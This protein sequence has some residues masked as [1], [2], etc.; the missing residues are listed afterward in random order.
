MNN[1]SAPAFQMH[2]CCFDYMKRHNKSLKIMLSCYAP[3]ILSLPNIILLHTPRFQN[4]PR[5][6]QILKTKPRK[7]KH[8]PLGPPFTILKYPALTQMA[9]PIPAPAAVDFVLVCSRVLSKKG[10]LVG[11]PVRPHPANPTLPLG[12]CLLRRGT[13]LG[14]RD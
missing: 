4:S 12:V 5:K 10:G 2:H 6:L 3:L 9:R 11:R 14:S 7:T 13:L 1:L 8:L